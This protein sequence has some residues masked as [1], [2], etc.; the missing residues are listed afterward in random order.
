[1]VINAAKFGGH[2]EICPAFIIFAFVKSSI[3]N[4]F[5]KKDELVEYRI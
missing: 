1:M 4:P 5:E 2:G 3:R